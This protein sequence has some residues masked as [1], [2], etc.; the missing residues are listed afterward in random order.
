MTTSLYD[1]RRQV[2]G[3]ALNL[4]SLQVGPNDET[5]DPHHDAGLEYSEEALDEAIANYVT[6]KRQART[7]EWNPWDQTASTRH[8]IDLSLTSP[9][10]D[11]LTA[12]G[13][14]LAIVNAMKDAGIEVLYIQATD[15]IG[16]GG[17][18]VVLTHGDEAHPNFLPFSG[19]SIADALNGQ[20]ELD[21]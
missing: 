11:G 9:E 20:P 12:E 21:F 2:L 15:D 19:T 5:V 3:A 16:L 1:A 17:E 4:A 8:V 14:K 13:L 6:A 10:S 7:F 18:G